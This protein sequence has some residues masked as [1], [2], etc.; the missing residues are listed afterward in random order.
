MFII[1]NNHGKWILSVVTI[2]TAHV[3]A[4]SEP[5]NHVEI[6]AELVSYT[7][8]AF[9]RIDSDN[10]HASGIFPMATFLVQ[11]P[12]DH[13]G[14]TL[15]IILFGGFGEEQ[16]F[17]RQDEILKKLKKRR[18]RNKIFLIELLEDLIESDVIRIDIEKVMRIMKK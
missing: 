6:E 15:E 2:L 14:R 11:S 10:F 16:S 4:L 18:S 17:K 13:E 8:A 12:R 9:H 7:K 3:Y 5:T 1:F